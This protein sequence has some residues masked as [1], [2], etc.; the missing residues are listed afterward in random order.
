MKNKIIVIILLVVIILVLGIVINLRNKGDNMV[1]EGGVVKD[2]RLQGYEEVIK[3]KD[4]V[5]FIYDGSGFNVSCEL[6]NNV[7]HVKSKGGNTY[8]RDGSYFVL[9]YDAKD[10]TLLTKLQTIIDKYNISKNN[11]YEHEGAGLPA[12]LGGSISVEYVS[13]EITLLPF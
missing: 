6:N 3:S 2:H 7:L 9:D 12:G 5:K 4:I 1:E 10:K 8:N 11:G 13:G